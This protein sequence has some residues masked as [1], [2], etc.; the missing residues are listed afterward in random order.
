M[1][2]FSIDMDVPAALPALPVVVF[3][4]ALQLVS[5]FSL[6]GA[7]L[8]DS[9]GVA[10]NNPAIAAA[11]KRPCILNLCA[12]GLSELNPNVRVPQLFLSVGCLR[13]AL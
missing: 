7:L 1:A 3:D 9:A 12:K 4:G 11:M 8:C 5:G 10:A 13:G 2:L 6:A